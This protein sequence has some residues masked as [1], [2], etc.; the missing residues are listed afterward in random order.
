MGGVSLG[1]DLEGQSEKAR[2]RTVSEE[3][4]FL[5]RSGASRVFGS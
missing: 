3:A 4:S 2:Q 5:R 1:G